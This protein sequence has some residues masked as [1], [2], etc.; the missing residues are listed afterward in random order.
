MNNSG[1]MEN[2]KEVN[3]GF[4]SQFQEI[5]SLFNVPTYKVCSWTRKKDTYYRLC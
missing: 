2:A 1:I 5:I 4:D 3:V